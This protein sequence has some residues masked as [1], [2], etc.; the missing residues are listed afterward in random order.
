MGQSSCKERPLCDSQDWQE[1]FSNC[2][3]GLRN[4]IFLWREPKICQEGIGAMDLPE[5]Y[6]GVKC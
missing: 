2:V 4:Q 3:N 5:D 1:L 6:E